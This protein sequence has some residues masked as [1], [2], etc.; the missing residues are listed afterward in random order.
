MGFSN[1]PSG[2]LYP[3]YGLRLWQ[4]Q[5]LNRMPN[6]RV[7]L[8]PNHSRLAVKRAAYYLS[9]AFS[10]AVLGPWLMCKLNLVK[11]LRSLVERTVCVQH[12]Y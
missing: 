5:G 9:F 3:G 7:W 12:S 10:A 8:Y 4:R 2:K 11:G 6:T 1:Y